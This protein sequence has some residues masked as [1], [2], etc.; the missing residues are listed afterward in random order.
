VR[1]RPVAPAG[2]AGQLLLGVL[3]GADGAG[4][5]APPALLQRLDVVHGLLA[6]AVV[7]EVVGAPGAVV[8]LAAGARDLAA[9][10]AAKT[11]ASICVCIY[12]VMAIVALRRKTISPCC[13]LEDQ[14]GL[15]PHTHSRSIS[16]NQYA[17]HHIPWQPAKYG[18]YTEEQSETSRSPTAAHRRIPPSLLVKTTLYTHTWMMM[19]RSIALILHKRHFLTIF[20]HRETKHLVEGKYK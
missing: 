7:A 2:A 13:R 8:A 10:V 15:L 6:G 20:K 14:L 17:F 16:R 19:G 9:L 5:H 11:L 1:L 18:C 3:E 12:K 4:P